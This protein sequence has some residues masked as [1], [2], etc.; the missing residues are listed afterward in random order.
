MICAQ[1]GVLTYLQRYYDHVPLHRLWTFATLQGDLN[2][3]EHAH[4]LDCEECRDALRVCLKAENFGAVLRELKRDGESED[5]SS[6]D[7]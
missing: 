3:S 7:F 1:G 6:F 5:Q 4:I 2:L